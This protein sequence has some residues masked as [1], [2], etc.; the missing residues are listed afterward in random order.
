MF[1]L[2]S[3][4]GWVAVYMGFTLVLA[5]CTLPSPMTCQ[6]G[7]QAQVHDV[8]CFG[9]DRPG[10]RV[11]DEQWANFLAEVVTPHFPDGLT[12][13]SGQGQWRSNSGEIIRESTHVLSL[14]HRQ[15]P[16]VG[17]AI[18]TIVTTYKQRFQQESV[19]RVRSAA[20][21]SFR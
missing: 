2:S 17:P 4:H 10:G 12:V 18:D 16:T 9:T 7:E 1:S 11:T 6:P 15:E 20:C 13:L 14:V 21:V 8:L 5:G 3:R 19:L